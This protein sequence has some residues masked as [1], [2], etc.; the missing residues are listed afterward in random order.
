[1]EERRLAEEQSSWK[2][3]EEEKK[4]SEAIYESSGGSSSSSS[5][6]SNSSSDSGIKCGGEEYEAPVEQLVYLGTSTSGGGNDGYKIYQV[7]HIQ[8]KLSKSL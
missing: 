8:A 3:K 5:S 4:Q 1:M 2:A 7:G 6:S